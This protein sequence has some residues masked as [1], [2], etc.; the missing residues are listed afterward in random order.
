MQSSLHLVGQLWIVHL[1]C[2]FLLKGKSL[3]WRVDVVQKH[4]LLCSIS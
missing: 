1:G 2:T 4:G 3:A